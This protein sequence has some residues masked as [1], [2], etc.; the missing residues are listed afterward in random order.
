M[1][2]SLNEI[3]VREQ[4]VDAGGSVGGVHFPSGS[5][6]LDGKGA[7][8]L[9]VHGYNNSRSAARGSFEGFV[10][11]LEAAS[12][13]DTLPWPVFGVQWPGDEP[14]AAISAASYPFKIKV[15]Q[16]A[17]A[18][19]FEHLT[20]IFGPGGAPIVLHVVAHSLGC[21]LTL[22]LLEL[23][24]R[25]APGA[26]VIV[27]S[28][29]LMA[30]A[31]PVG[32][33]EQDGRLRRGVESA[34]RVCVL[35]STGDAVL[36]WAFPLGQ[37]VVGDGF[38]PTAIGRFGGPGGIWTRSASMAADGGL[39]GHSSYWSGVESA[40][41]AAG[42]MGVAVANAVPVTLTPAHVLPPANV[43]NV[44]SVSARSLPF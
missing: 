3:S 26:N 22:E 38:F 37:T 24:A 21:R 9:F 39:Y 16:R 11:G 43:I 34:G 32:K 14:N 6:T 28:V 17:A 31:V 25:G 42:M 15:A 29:T 30:A 33:V 4:G 20:G 23:L 18:K 10:A 8:V 41:A 40:S 27:S 35:H 19:I 36:H 2:S 1:P 7:A 12:G 13:R 5:D 44:R